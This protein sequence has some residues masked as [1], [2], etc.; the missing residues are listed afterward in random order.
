MN[1]LTYEEVLHD[2]EKINP[3]GVSPGLK[4]MEK[5]MAALENP[6]DGLKTVHVAGT[7]GKGT[8]CELIASV[9]SC[10]GYKTGLYLSPHVS[11]FRERMQVNGEMISREK[12]T[13]AAEKV[14]KAIGR[15]SGENVQ[16][17]K[18]AAVTAM[19][20]L[21]FAEESCDIVVLEVGLG[22]RFDATNI[23][24]N[25]LVSVITPVSLD[26]TAILG[27][28]VGKIAFEKSGIIKQGG[29]V[30][31]SPD[32]PAEALEVIKAAASGRS[33]GLIE[34]GETV[35]ASVV[36]E[37]LSGTVLSCRGAALKLP[38]IGMHQVCNAKTAVAALDVLRYNY[39]KIDV[40]ALKKGFASAKLP[41]RLEVLSLSPAVVVDGG[42]NPSAA[43]A[44]AAAVRRY[45]G[46]RDILAVMGMLA[47]KDTESVVSELS[48]VFSEVI[49]VA[50]SSERA[51]DAQS[52]AACWQRHGKHAVP[53]EDFDSAVSEAF[54]MLPPGGAVV[55]CGSLYLAGD[56]RGR[57]LTYLGSKRRTGR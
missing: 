37:D 21:W 5:L 51:M 34:A 30:V 4:G 56:M 40:N 26:H 19:A 23:V 10:A 43:S 55:V 48:G 22:G 41:G 12:L 45:L 15:L 49:T 27:D 31:V 50:P 47:D 29:T 9:L 42:H 57:I 46:G 11:D 7:N 28:T 32:Q 14:F 38:F 54:S 3:F 25:P 53:A 17:T 8:T 44:L 18:F 35:N 20:L 24:K 33:A 13:A 2:I 6:Q 16:I 52:L 39:N 1:S 36:Y